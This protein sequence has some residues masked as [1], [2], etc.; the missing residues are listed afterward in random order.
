M[1]VPPCSNRFFFILQVRLRSG[2]A[3]HVSPQR[4]S[5]VQLSGLMLD[6]ETG[7]MKRS[8]L[9]HQFR[10]N[11]ETLHINP[12]LFEKSNTIKPAPRRSSRSSVESNETTNVNERRRTATA[13]EHNALYRGTPCVYRKCAEARAERQEKMRT[14]PLGFSA[15]QTFSDLK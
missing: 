12:I 1:D 3:L 11:S 7:Q 14:K 4:D 9:D 5:T 2:Q 10:T 6:S 8:L 13:A 15:F